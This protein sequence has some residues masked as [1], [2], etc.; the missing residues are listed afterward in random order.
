MIDES[1]ADVLWAAI[2]HSAELFVHV[3][4]IMIAHRFRNGWKGETFS[5]H[6]SSDQYSLLGHPRF[7]CDSGITLKGVSKC[8]GRDSKGNSHLREREA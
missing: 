5:D 6:T 4:L 1:G 7:W 2:N 3:R 8:A